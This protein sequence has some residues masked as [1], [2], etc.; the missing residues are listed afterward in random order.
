[1]VSRQPPQEAA[2]APRLRGTGKQ[3][4]CQDLATLVAGAGA[5]LCKVGGRRGC[6]SRCLE[7]CHLDSRSAASCSHEQETRRDQVPLPG[8]W[9]TLLGAAGQSGM[10][11]ALAGYHR[12]GWKD[13]E[14][15]Q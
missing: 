15:R 2:S 13:L 14:L 11:A 1:M 9:G 12:A 3:A 8:P 4:K 10:C 5:G 6:F 7:S